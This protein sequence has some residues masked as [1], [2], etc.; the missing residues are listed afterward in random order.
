MS[1]LFSES[2]RLDKTYMAIKENPLQI[3]ELK[4]FEGDHKSISVEYFS[5]KETY[6]MMIKY[7]IE[8][9]GQVEQHLKILHFKE[10]YN[11][12]DF[13]KAKKHHDDLHKDDEK[14]EEKD[15]AAEKAKEAASEKAE[16]QDVDKVE[17]EAGIDGE[18][19]IEEEPE[20][21]PIPDHSRMGKLVFETQLHTYAGTAGSTQAAKTV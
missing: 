6:Y 4:G 17:G 19:P 5:W 1:E 2:M 12:V 10:G 14:D 7:A 15:E 20:E 3:Q 18:V 9:D 21:L 16:E 11:D 8:V 13:K